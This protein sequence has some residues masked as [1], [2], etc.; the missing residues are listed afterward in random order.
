M[1]TLAA[2]KELVLLRV[3]EFT[4]EIAGE[5][6]D[7]PVGDVEEELKF[8]A[9]SILRKMDRHTALL[10]TTFA[11][12]AT[13]GVAVTENSSPQGT[14]ITLPAD[15]LR[16]VSVK[17]DSWEQAV[18]EFLSDASPRYREQKYT[19]RRGTVEKPL[20]FIIPY[21][22]TGNAD[23]TNMALEVFPNDA[24]LSSLVYVGV[25]DPEDM[26]DEFMDALCWEAAGRV[27]LIME[28]GEKA[29]MAFESAK[30]AIDELNLGIYGGDA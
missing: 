24:T 5:I 18:N 23:I 16:F 20:V 10:A 27:L 3:D 11:T 12:D 17:M 25:K 13:T 1:A 9:K 30:R 15:F 28:L 26:P 21:D 14:V 7:A 29:K 6:P 4:E 19:R 8:A 2:L 22:N